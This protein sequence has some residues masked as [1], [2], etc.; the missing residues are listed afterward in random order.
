M[1]FFI[2]NNLLFF[3]LFR[4]RQVES[5]NF[6]LKP[7]LKCFE[8]D[9]VRPETIDFDGALAL[10]EKIRE[11]IN[12]LQVPFIH[13]TKEDLQERVE[14]VAEEIFKRWPDL[15]RG[16]MSANSNYVE[17]KWNPMNE[18]SSKSNTAVRT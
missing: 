7:S 10:D 16:Q 3:S 4:L 2:H 12:D 6:V 1:I 8:F 15:K 17:Y 18:K 14:F 5:L 9:G 11:T 13:I